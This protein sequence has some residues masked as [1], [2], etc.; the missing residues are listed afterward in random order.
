MFKLP[1][2]WIRPTF[3]GKGR[4]VPGSLEAHA[5]GFRCGIGGGGWRAGRPY[6]LLGRPYCCFPGFG[7]LSDAM[8]CGVRPKS[9]SLKDPLD[10]WE[11]RERQ[12]LLR[13]T[14]PLLLFLII[15]P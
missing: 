6:T 5:N 4:K 10:P 12:P 1:D 15:R 9:H 14:A 7:G 11:A 2:L 13:C 8:P 3:G